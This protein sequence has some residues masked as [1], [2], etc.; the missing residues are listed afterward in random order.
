MKYSDTDTNVLIRE[1]S[2][3]DRLSAILRAGVAGEPVHEAQTQGSDRADRAQE[4]EKSGR[5]HVR[6]EAADLACAPV[7]DAGHQEPGRHGRR[8]DSRG[9]E[10][11]E[12]AET[13]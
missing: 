6:P 11:G 9:S 5:T 3:W 13:R 12:Q 8:A 2:T 1:L 4:H 7:A 10:P